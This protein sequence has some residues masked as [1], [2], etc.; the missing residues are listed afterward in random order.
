MYFDVFYFAISNI[1]YLMI[2][3]I[4]KCTKIKE[5]QSWRLDYNFKHELTDREI[6]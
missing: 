1:S 5:N 2:S 3:N 6:T 4:L